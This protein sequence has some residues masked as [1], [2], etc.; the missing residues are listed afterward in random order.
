MHVLIYP[1]RQSVPPQGR[2][3]GPQPRPSQRSSRELK[4]QL[5]WQAPPPAHP[6]MDAFETAT[7]A[8]GPHGHREHSAGHRGRHTH[9]RHP[10]NPA[11]FCQPITTVT[12]SASVTV[13]V[14]SAPVSSQSPSATYPGYAAAD[15][16]Q[17]SSPSPEPEPPYQDP[18]VPL[19]T[20]AGGR[21][22][23]VKAMELQDLEF[24]AAD[25]NFGKRVS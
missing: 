5:H 14:H 3:A 7:E 11:P 22:D 12:A 15:S 25:G 10:P 21:R 19:D 6:R 16:Y 23:R 9:G 4:S 20:P 1:F 17:P 18:H 24:E 13:A 2:D 8:G